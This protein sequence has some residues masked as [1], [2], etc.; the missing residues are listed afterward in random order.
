MA[1][2]ETQAPLAQSGGDWT[3]E[4]MEFRVDAVINVHPTTQLELGGVLTFVSPAGTRVD[5]SSTSGQELAIDMMLDAAEH[6]VAEERAQ[7]ELSRLCD[8]LSYFHGIRIA[9]SCVRS[10]SSEQGPSDRSGVVL[11]KAHLSIAGRLSVIA[12]VPLG[13]DTIDKL[14][15]EMEKERRPGVESA[16][17]SWREA[18][19]VE[20][21]ALRYLLLYR[22]LEFLIGENALTSWIKIQEPSVQIC[23]ENRRR[24]GVTVYTWVRDN[25][26][27]KQRSFPFQEMHSLLPRLE[28]LVRRAI[29][30]KLVHAS[31]STH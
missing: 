12:S 6:A 22:L 25:I 2:P 30:E 27:R 5:L 1:A 28:A 15:L 20:S 3:G 4:T 21:W 10:V 8:F 18:T 29:E 26:H 31:E 11:G 13:Q 7:L 24:T 14:T 23:H 17:Y 9:E 19:G 16:L